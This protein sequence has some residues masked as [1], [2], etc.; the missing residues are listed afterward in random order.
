[1]YKFTSARVFS[2]FHSEY[3]CALVVAVS[4]KKAAFSMALGNEE[5]MHE[6]FPKHSRMGGERMKKENRRS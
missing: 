2:F 1:M 3:N 6:C 4:E 5:P